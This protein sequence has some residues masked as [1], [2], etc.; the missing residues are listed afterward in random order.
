MRQLCV[1]L[2]GLFSCTIFSAA[3]KTSEELVFSLKDFE[4]VT[5]SEFTEL[6][7]DVWTSGRVKYVGDDIVLTV[8]KAA[9][10]MIVSHNLK[11]GK[12][13]RF[14]S[15]G[16]GPG[17]CLFVRDIIVYGDSIYVSSINDGKILTFY[18]N[19]KKKIEY[20]HEES[21]DPYCVRAIPLPTGGIL[22]LPLTGERFLRIYKDKVEE[23][24]SFLKI[25][26]DQNAL[27]NSAV[28][29]MTAASPN[30]RFVC[31]VYQDIDCIEVYSNDF[32]R[33]LRLLG[34]EKSTP[35]VRVK[36][37]PF[38]VAFTLEPSKLVY[39]S[40]SV[41][42]KGFV[43]GYIGQ[44]FK[45]SDEVSRNIKELLYFDWDGRCRTR[46]LLPE[47]VVY[48]DVDWDG[49]RMIGVTGG[50]VPRLVTAKLKL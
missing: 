10:E 18:K 29:S 8:E 34:P 31:S 38:G 41:S 17:E 36:E 13:Q 44:L 48:F 1:F 49:G 47:E 40:L 24:G 12:N 50:D 22:C 27:N 30:G 20:A 15:R 43:V 35:K 26:G 6:P 32:T 21:F 23:L 33:V 4:L 11:T 16:R 25:K 5:I 39:S 7:A 2:L 46:F 28:Q 42:D 14:L 9:Q 45:N 3:T 37:N 19:A